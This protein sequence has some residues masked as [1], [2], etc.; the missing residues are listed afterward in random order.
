MHFR[1]NFVAVRIQRHSL[2][3]GEFANALLD[4]VSIAH[5]HSS[6]AFG[7]HLVHGGLTDFRFTQAA[8]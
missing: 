7:A 6:Q 8:H 2:A 3:E 4:A 1:G 5:N